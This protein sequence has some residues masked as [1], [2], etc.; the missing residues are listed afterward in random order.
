MD[1]T[2]TPF[3]AG[4]WTVLHDELFST[5]VFVSLDEAPPLNTD[6]FNG[7]LDWLTN[8]SKRYQK[9]GNNWTYVSEIE[10]KE[11]KKLKKKAET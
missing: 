4:W 6:Q 11:L 7:T 9:I 8:M 2:E 5:Y 10:D 3:E 1:K